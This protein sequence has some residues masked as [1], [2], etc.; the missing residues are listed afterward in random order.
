MKINISNMNTIFKYLA[1]SFFTVLVPLLV[2]PY[3]LHKLPFVSKIS[4]TSRVFVT[5]RFMDMALL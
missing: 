4:L 3:K 2:T 1:I 5:T